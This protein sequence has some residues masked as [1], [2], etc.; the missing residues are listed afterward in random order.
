MQN[1]AMD[2]IDRVSFGEELRSD[3]EAIAR[4]NEILQADVSDPDAH[5]PFI[6]KVVYQQAQQALT[7]CY[8]Y[9]YLTNQENESPN[10]VTDTI[11]DLVEIMD[12]HLNDL[13]PN[14]STDH[15]DH[16]KYHLDKAHAYRVA[17]RL[18][19]G[20][21]RASNARQLVARLR[22]VPAVRLLGTASAVPS[23]PTMMRKWPSKNLPINWKPATSS[24][25]AITTKG[26]PPAPSKPGDANCT[27]TPED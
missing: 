13:D 9:G 4:L 12:N 18:R 3:D 2:A 19:R 15:F 1:A 6:L 10:N 7:N 23:R 8:Q 22:P 14:D 24:S 25:L 17:W 21:S 16:F 26:S 5:L 20:H 27:R 11:A